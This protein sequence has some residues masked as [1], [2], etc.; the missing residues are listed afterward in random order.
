MSIDNVLM[1]GAETAVNLP[2]SLTV[3]EQRRPA[4]AA[5]FRRNHFPAPSVDPDTWAVAL[6]GAMSEPM[7]IP[8]VTLRTFEHRTLP[9]VLECAGT[10]VL[11]ST[12]PGTGSRGGWA[13]SPRPC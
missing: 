8:A 7:V 3:L 10:G 5:H 9:V 1:G 12:S 2:A 4:A 13:R 11:S 6:G